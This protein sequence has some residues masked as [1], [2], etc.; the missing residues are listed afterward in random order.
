MI[1][2][3][4]RSIT[5]R[6]FCFGEVEQRVDSRGREAKEAGWAGH[7][8]RVGSGNGNQEDLVVVSGTRAE[9]MARLKKIYELWLPHNWIK[10]W[11]EHQRRLT[12]ATL[13]DEEA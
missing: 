6:R 1:R 11:C 13:A 3:E 2:V 9:M 5:S 7:I 8:V 12:Y 4:G 10:R